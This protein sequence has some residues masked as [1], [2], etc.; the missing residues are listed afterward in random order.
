[1]WTR[2]PHLVPELFFLVFWLISILEVLHHREYFIW[3]LLLL[4]TGD[5]VIIEDFLPFLRHTGIC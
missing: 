3:V 1:V 4:S 2:I 5:S